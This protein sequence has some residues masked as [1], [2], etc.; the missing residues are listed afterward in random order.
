M[1]ERVMRQVRVIL[2]VLAAV[3]GAATG[4][5]A[6]VKATAERNDAAAASGEYR[7]K[8]VPRPSAADAA[9]KAKVS[10]LDGERDRNGG[11]VATLT[12]GRVPAGADVPRA[13]FF[14]A[15]GAD[16]GRVLLDLGAP[17]SVKQVNTY[18]WH[19]DTRGP[20]V[21]KLYASDGAGADF[22]AEPKRGTDPTAAGWTLIAAVDTRPKEGPPGG[23]YGVSVADSTG[24]PVGKYRYLLLDVSRTEDKDPFG[25]TFFSEI[26]VIDAS[27]PAADAPAVA[28]G[29]GGGGRGGNRGPNPFAETGGPRD[30]IVAKID[31]GY[32]I[33]FD[34]T[35]TPELKQW[36][37]TKLKP[38]CVTWYPKIVAMLPSEGYEAPKKFPVIF[39]REMRGVAATGGTRVVC[40]Y[41]WF[42][43]NLEGEAVGAVVHELVHVA[44]QYGRARQAQADAA[45]GQRRPRNPGWLVEGLADYIRWFNFEPQ[46]ARPRPN[47]ARA[48][49]NDSYRTTGHFLN[50]V[51]EKYDKDAIKKL[52]AAMREGRFSDDMW[53][54]MTGKTAEELNEEW[55]KSL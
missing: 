36:V 6:E 8:T 16:G 9:G 22:K 44:Q 5:R 10:L 38:A 39:R 14:F 1:E 2:V 55:K 49:Y 34:V 53:K 27:A 26:D 43:K 24:A 48:N 15:Q 18:S 13:N 54:Q 41:D 29:P 4:A 23:Q 33:D 21:Y 47:P 52:N 40:A 51:V 31:G 25:N 37:E 45:P 12:D 35:E 3:L 19:G 46:S 30:L 11:D 42:S 17:T 50:Y 7:F 32:E 28:A 20:Q